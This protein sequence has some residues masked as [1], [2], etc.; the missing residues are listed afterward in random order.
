MQIYNQGVK[1]PGKVGSQ[2][3]CNKELTIDRKDRFST[4]ISLTVQTKK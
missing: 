1:I 4:L 2:R 3:F